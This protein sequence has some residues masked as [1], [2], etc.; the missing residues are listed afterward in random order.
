MAICN[1]K[2]R[3]FNHK[4]FLLKKNSFFLI[5]ADRASESDS[6][7]NEDSS[8]NQ[9]SGGNQQ[10]TTTAHDGTTSIKST[11]KDEKDE[12]AATPQRDTIVSQKD[13]STPSGNAKNKISNSTISAK[14]G[15]H[16]NKK[17]KHR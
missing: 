13:T 16:I 15:G 8:D 17:I 11:G 10:N 14:K 7:T 6:I 4:I 1:R 2:M 3:K 5:I 12:R 9:I